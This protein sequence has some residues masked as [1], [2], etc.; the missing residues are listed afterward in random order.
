MS[1]QLSTLPLDLDDSLILVFDAQAAM[2]LYRELK[3]YANQ[4]TPEMNDV[5]KSINHYAGLDAPYS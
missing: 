3:R 1:N 4:F 5:L 2:D